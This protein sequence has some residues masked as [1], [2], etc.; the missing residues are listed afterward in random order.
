MEKISPNYMPLVA[1]ILGLGISTLI[2]W[3]STWQTI[4]LSGL[5]FGL[6]AVGLYEGVKSSNEIRLNSLEQD[7]KGMPK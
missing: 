6:S 7:T 3:E 2:N 4:I 1:L 5:F